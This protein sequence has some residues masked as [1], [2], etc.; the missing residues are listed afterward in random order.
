MIP[1]Y[2][3]GG[4][5]RTLKKTLQ[6]FQFPVSLRPHKKLCRTFYEL[7]TLLFKECYK[8]R[9]SLYLINIKGKFQQAVLY[10]QF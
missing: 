9:S 6:G 3:G 5:N 7:R 10:I 1:K 4:E 8:V 2:G